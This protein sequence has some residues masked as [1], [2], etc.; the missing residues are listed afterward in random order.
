MKRPL[1]NQHMI[2]ELYLAEAKERRAKVFTRVSA[3][4]IDRANRAGTAA[5]IAEI[6]RTVDTHPS[7]GKTIN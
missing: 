4:A 6:R 3:T 5:V 7:M 1:L 2:K